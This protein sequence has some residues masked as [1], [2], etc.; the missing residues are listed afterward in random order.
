MSKTILRKAF[1]YGWY[2]GQILVYSIVITVGTMVAYSQTCCWRKFCVQHLDQQ[3]AGRGRG[4]T[5]GL[6]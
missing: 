4:I 3:A 5:L 2:T 6:A 1:H